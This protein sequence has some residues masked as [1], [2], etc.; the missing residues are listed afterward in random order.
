MSGPGPG[1]GEAFLFLPLGNG[2]RD[3]DLFA[4]DTGTIISIKLGNNFILK[5]AKDC[6]FCP[7]TN[8]GILFFVCC[9]PRQAREEC[10]VPPVSLSSCWSSPLLYPE[11]GEGNSRSHGD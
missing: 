10:W 1:T 9:D 3:N 4:P 7:W 2:C 6:L 11:D 5:K 8:G